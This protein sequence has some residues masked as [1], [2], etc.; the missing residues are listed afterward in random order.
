MR[1][2]RY[3]LVAV[4]AISLFSSAAFAADGTFDRTLKVNGP[5]LLGIDTGSGNIHIVTGPGNLVHIVGH[6]HSSNNWF[7]GASADDKVQ[8]VVKNPPI[9]Q[10][11]NIISVGRDF[12]VNNISIDYEITTPRGTDLR[13]DSGSGNIEAD[14]IGGPVELKTGSGN[15]TG[16]GLSDHVSLEAGDGNITASV[17]SALDVKAQTG[18]GDIK[19]QGVQSGL[20][21]Q[22]GSGNVTVGGR[23]LANWKLESGSGNVTLNIGSA[24]F[25]LNASTGSGD[26]AYTGGNLKQQNTASKQHVM[27]GCERRRPIGA[28]HDGFGRYQGELGPVFR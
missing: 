10:A 28:H 5:V 8:S 20:W 22:T 9:N 13:A 21:A 11:G 3:A 18:S 27:G 7:G 14:N 4:A 15:V 6:V 26:I 16:S 1:P 19:L 25:L 12:H 23:P 17:S 24:P 2:V